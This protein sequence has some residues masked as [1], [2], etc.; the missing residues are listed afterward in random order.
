M[1]VFQLAG[2][3]IEILALGDLPP[4]DGNQF[5]VK[6]LIA[7]V[8]EQAEQVPI[9]GLV[10]CHPLSLALDNQ[11]DR[12]ALHATGRK[13]R[14]NFLPQQRR[15]LVAEEPID[16]PPRLLGFNEVFVDLPGMRKRFLDRLFRDF[17]EHQPM[18]GHLWLE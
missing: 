1:I 16:D 17:V 15:D 3:G 4:A 13:P 14:A 2:G 8:G 11:A 5:G 12:G 10:E 6:F 7:G 18:H 9:R